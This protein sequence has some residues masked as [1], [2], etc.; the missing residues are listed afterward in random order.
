M[1][2]LEQKILSE[3]RV[4]DGNILKVDEFL[5][6]KLD[7]AFLNEIGKEFKRIFADKK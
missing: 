7:I 6:H 5:N 2:L 3:G 1:K 4:K